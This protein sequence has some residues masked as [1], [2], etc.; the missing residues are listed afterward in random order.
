[1]EM[2]GISKN[3]DIHLYYSFVNFGTEPLCL[4]T[5][6]SQPMTYQQWTCHGA[7]SWG[8]SHPPSELPQ[9]LSGKAADC[10]W[11]E[12]WDC[13]LF[14]A[15]DKRLKRWFDAVIW[16]LVCELVPQQ[17]NRNTLP[18]ASPWSHIHFFVIEEIKRM[19]KT[20]KS[21]WPTCSFTKP[22]TKNAQTQP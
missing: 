8:W 13:A 18:K 9:S 20:K 2:V 15:Y 6:T 3:N 10:W 5:V 11:L 1:M 14:T 19:K 22:A 21:L 4:E 12:P 17:T 7:P 16:Q